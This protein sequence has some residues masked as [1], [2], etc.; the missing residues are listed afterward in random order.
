MSYYLEPLGQSCLIMKNILLIFTLNFASKEFLI[1]KI[2]SFLTVSVSSSQVLRL[3]FHRT[4][5]KEIL[6]E[7]ELS[8]E[9][10]LRNYLKRE[11]VG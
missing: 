1:L 3:F 9:V 4:T 6:A 8:L 10:K 2:P 5:R 11:Q 7:I